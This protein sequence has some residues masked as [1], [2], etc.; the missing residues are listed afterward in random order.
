MA[1]VSQRYSSETDRGRHDCPPSLDA[2][3]KLAATLPLP[4]E[5]QSM[6]AGRQPREAVA[7]ALAGYCVRGTQRVAARRADERRRR[8]G[9][10]ASTIPLLKACN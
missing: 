2:E 10:N 5:Q 4:P 3:N 7:P 1:N 9:L 8:A 6:N